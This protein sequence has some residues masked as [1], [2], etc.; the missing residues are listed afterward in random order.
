MLQHQ[1]VDGKLVFKDNINYLVKA[2]AYPHVHVGREW[3]TENE[4]DRA[5][6]ISDIQT[7]MNDFTIKDFRE[8]E[9]LGYYRV[10]NTFTKKE[11]RFY[12]EKDDELLKDF[13][14]N[15]F[16]I[17]LN[18]IKK[19]DCLYIVINEEIFK[20]K[21]EGDAVL[22]NTVIQPIRIEHLIVDFVMLFEMKN[23]VDYSQPESVVVKNL[24]PTD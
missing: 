23:R 2:K 16:S 10:I 4:N 5:V 22:V 7:V 21:M 14:N 19:K 12:V 20:D 8:F 3:E 6:I 13:E 24:F 9:A 18:E 11:Y 15:A 17:F 1:I